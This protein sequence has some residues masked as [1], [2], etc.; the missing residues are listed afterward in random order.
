MVFAI[1]GFGV[2]VVWDFRGFGLFWDLGIFEIWGFRELG[3]LR[4]KNFWFF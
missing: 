3:F 1:L 2:F 4:F